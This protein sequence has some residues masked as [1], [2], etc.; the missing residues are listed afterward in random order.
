MDDV[1]GELGPVDKRRSGATCQYGVMHVRCGQPAVTIRPRPSG[2]GLNAERWDVC[3]E[4]ADFLDRLRSNV[5][6]HKSL[7]DRLGGY[8]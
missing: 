2:H 8:R 4:H 5:T 3:R 6:K 1:A 7:L